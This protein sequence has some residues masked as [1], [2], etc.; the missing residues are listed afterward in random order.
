V[1]A[2]SDTAAWTRAPVPN[3]RRS[4]SRPHRFGRHTPPSSVR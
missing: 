3:A 2:R 1:S 4:T